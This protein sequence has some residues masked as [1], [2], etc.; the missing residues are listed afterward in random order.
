MKRVF[1]FGFYGQNNFGDDLFCYVIKTSLGNHEEIKFIGATQSLFQN[2]SFFSIRLNNFFI[3]QNNSIGKVYRIFLN[4][5][6]VLC[7]DKIL[8]GGGSVFGKYASYKQRSLV[9]LLAKLLN[10]KV[11]AL[12]VSVGPFDSVEQ[13][14]KFLR[15]LSNLDAIWVRDQKSEQYLLKYNVPYISH[16]DMVFSLRNK[17][18][19][20]NTQKNLM[21]IAVHELA[22]IDDI[23]TMVNQ[24][25]SRNGTIKFISLDFESEVV[26]SALNEKINSQ[27]I[28][29]IKY[30]NN[31]IE[32]IEV[33]KTAEYVVT[34]KLHGAIISYILNIPFYL[35]EYQEKCTE[36]LKLI[37]WYEYQAEAKRCYSYSICND[38]YKFVNIIEN[39]KELSEF[40]L[41]V[42][43][44]S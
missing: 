10:K 32:I 8:Y 41:R 12:G 25:L 20:K 29:Y 16:G 23:A 9:I 38:L 4:I 13:E 34:S 17:F 22:Y 37:N 26:A 42:I 6:S 3:T 5:M 2:N 15:L 36:F 39:D 19:E 1:V 24:H 28:K 40:L 35:Y 27:N 18:G 7:A 33:F 31:L 43:N 11:Y 30:S 14:N 44:E 21:I